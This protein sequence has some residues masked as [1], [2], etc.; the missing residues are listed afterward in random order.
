MKK[1]SDLSQTIPFY[2]FTAG[3]FLIIV[4]KNFL[5][6]G[7][8]LDGVIYS[9]VSKN[10]ANGIGTFWN[11][12]FT[13]TCM[14]DFHEHPPLAFALQGIFFKVFGE[15]RLVDKM[16]SMITVVITGIIILRIWKTLKYRHGWFPLLIWLV[17]PTVFWASCNNILENTLTIF[18]SLSILFYIKNRENQSFLFLFL[19]GFVLSLGFL[20]KGFVAFFPWTMPFW[21]WLILREKSFGKMISDSTILLLSSVIPLLLL[22]IL[23]PVAKISLLKYFDKQVIVSLKTVINVDS[24]FYILKRLIFEI[25]PVAIFCIFILSLGRMKKFPEVIRKENCMKSL[26]FALL[27]LS[28]VIPIMISMKQSGFYILPVY[29]LFAMSAGILIYPYLD[30]LISGINGSS[31]GFLIFRLISYCFLIIGITLSIYLSD[32]FSRDEEKLKDI[33]A[34][35]P[36]TTEGSIININPAMD[37]DWR[38]HAYFE[39]FKS[40][41]LD[42]NLNNRRE[43]LLIGNEYYSDTLKKSYDFVS[44]NTTA[45]K[46]FKRKQE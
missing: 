5:L 29:P 19:S 26:M 21:M 16:Y 3:V 41:S 12:Q 36:E 17:T 14:S 20:T 1:S 32:R 8:F 18:T 33:Y 22:I 30:Y 27:G 28:G 37:N 6:K 39:R 4:S 44:L 11:P 45:Y 31:T 9:D 34:I 43:Y 35:L 2:L 25:L 15:D 24:R 10:L 7:M 13:A 23:F 38:L 46:L 40:V 42:R